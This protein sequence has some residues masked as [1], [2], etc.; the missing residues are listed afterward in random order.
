MAIVTTTKCGAVSVTLPYFVPSNGMPC[1]RFRVQSTRH[2][3]RRYPRHRV[4]PRHEGH[5]PSSNN[6]QNGQLRHK[7]LQQNERPTGVVKRAAC[8]ELDPGIASDTK[9]VSEDIKFRKEM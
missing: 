1:V 3:Y 6:P 4:N 9:A 2:A 7:R 5:A 8:A